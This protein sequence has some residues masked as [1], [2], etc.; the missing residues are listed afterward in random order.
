MIDPDKLLA[1]MFE[2]V[3]QEYDENF[4]MLYAL[5]IGLGGDP[6]DASQ[7][8]Y[9]QEKGAVP[10]KAFP[11]MAVVLGFPGSW[12]ADPRTGIDFSRI[13]HGEESVEWNRPLPAAG[14]VI[15]RH[16]VISVE[17]KGADKGAVI[18]YDK[19][20]FDAGSMELIA[21]VRHTTFARGDGGFS[22]SS[23]APSRRAAT[24]VEAPI[25]QRSWKTATLPQQALLYRLCADRNPLHSDPP[26]ARDAGFEAPILHGLCT[27]GVAAHG[28]VAQWCGYDSDRLKRLQARFSSPVTPGDRLTVRSSMDGATIRFDVWNETRG[29]IAL[30]NGTAVVAD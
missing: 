23:L 25:P 3:V 11:T 13:V 1:W 29:R 7:L 18:A 20:L 12:M 16:K 15:A 5:S 17:D 22:G 8:A 28:I 24:P 9:V 4:S 10:L 19:Y 21:T 14:K 27:Y 2:D 30:S 26:T 6:T